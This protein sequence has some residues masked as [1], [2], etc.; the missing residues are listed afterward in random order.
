M[1][2]FNQGFTVSGG[3]TYTPPEPI[4]PGA[5]GVFNIS[6]YTGTGA[7]RSISNG[8]DLG[9][10]GGLVWI[11][12]RDNSSGPHS[13]F[14]TQRGA[15]NRLRPVISAAQTT[16]SG[17]VTSFNSDGFSLGSS[18][19]VNNIG[20]NFVAWCFRQSAGF[21]DIV[22]YTG[23]GTSN[24][25]IAHS[26]GCTPGMMIV[27]KTNSASTWFVWHKNLPVNRTVYLNGDFSSQFFPGLFDATPTNTNFTVG[28]GLNSTGDQYIAYIF[29]DG[30]DTAAQIF[31]LNQ[32][33]SIIKCGQFTSLGNGLQPAVNLG[34][35]PQYILLKNTT[36]AQNWLI[37]D[38]ARG[39]VDGGD[40]PQ[41]YANT[42]QA[43]V[44]TSTNVLRTTATGFEGETSF[45]GSSNDVIY[46]AIRS[47]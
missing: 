31:G 40:D 36:A 4:P 44:T 16:E 23:D 20:N 33:E 12:N 39:I 37:F 22:G 28:T 24:R 38:S 29:A 34:W 45:W 43:E 17:T 9:G 18:S 14:D 11:K 7:A 26:L 42:E 13:L 2:T 25:Q 21:M 15:Q 35:E 47:A 3:I 30:D 46:L 10:E 41:L 8:L 1:T 27:K 32:D 5:G 6:L 19:S